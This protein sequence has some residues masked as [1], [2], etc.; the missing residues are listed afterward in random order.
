MIALAWFSMT[1][2][3]AISDFAL[4]GRS[5]AEIDEQVDALLQKI[6]DKPPALPQG[7]DSSRLRGFA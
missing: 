3:L 5:K 4:T 7:F 1:Q 2:P 6:S